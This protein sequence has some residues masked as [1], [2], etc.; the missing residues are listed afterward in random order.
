M[1]NNS[2][3]FNGKTITRSEGSLNNFLESLWYKFDSYMSDCE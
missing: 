2:T 1:S 3:K